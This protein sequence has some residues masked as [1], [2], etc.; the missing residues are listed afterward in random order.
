MVEAPKVIHGAGENLHLVPLLATSRSSVSWRADRYYRGTRSPALHRMSH[1]LRQSRG[2]VSTER[3]E[4]VAIA[5][6]S[7][8]DRRVTHALLNGVRMGPLLDGESHRR[9]AEIMPSDV[10]EARVPLGTAP[11]LAHEAGHVGSPAAGIDED[12]AGLAGLRPLGELPFEKHAQ[13]LRQVH[14]AAACPRL[15]R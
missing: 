7:D 2:Q 1:G 9:V 8:G 11:Y 13:R 6:E 12:E 5:V 4:Q 3:R 14:T 10:L 15:W